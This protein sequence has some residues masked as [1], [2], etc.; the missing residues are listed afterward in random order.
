MP[1]DTAFYR[2]DIPEVEAVVELSGLDEGEASQINVSLSGPHSFMANR[3]LARAS[4]APNEQQA[5]SV[6]FGR[7]PHHPGK[8]TFW[9]SQNGFSGSRY[10]GKL[11]VAPG[12]RGTRTLRASL[13]GRTLRLRVLGGKGIGIAGAK[14]SIRENISPCSPH[15]LHWCTTTTDDQGWALC[16]FA[17]EKELV[18]WVW[19]EKEGWARF[20][21]PP[22]QDMLTNLRPGRR[23]EAWLLAENGQPATGFNAFFTPRGEFHS[24]QFPTATDDAGRIVLHNVPGTDGVLA[25]TSFVATEAERPVVLLPLEK[26][27]PAF[28]S[29]V[30]V[31]E[32]SGKLRLHL[33]SARDPG[34]EDT[35]PLLFLEKDGLPLMPPVDTF[36]GHSAA[37]RYALTQ[38]WRRLPEGKYRLVAVDEE[39]T[40]LFR[41][42]PF[43]VRVGETTKLSPS[44][45]AP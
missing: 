44:V 10:L 37:Q 4:P 29:P 1:G 3:P 12:E 36:L 13:A 28:P 31:A 23:I 39:C 18:F 26:G 41:S 27:Q 42:K 9:V 15:S 5:K 6:R 14:V 32:Q 45:F 22:E 11:Q 17:P 7:V 16:R 40:T 34:Q 33:S 43:I 35:P 21:S 2:F 38:S 19:H 8:Y 30:M 24:L 25:F 20:S